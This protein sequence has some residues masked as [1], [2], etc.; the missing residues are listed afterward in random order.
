MERKEN[1][2]VL[3]PNLSH[4]LREKGLDA[5]NN[6]QFHEALACFD[7]LKEYGLQNEHSE[8]AAVVSLLELQ[9]LQ[10]AK[11]RCYALLENAE[12]LFA[13]VL[14]M[15]ITILVQLHDYTAIAETAEMVLHK[16]KV[17]EEQKQK[18]SSL[19]SFAQKMKR[20]EQA[21]LSGEEEEF[22]AIFQ[23]NDV[24]KQLQALQLLKQRGRVRAFSFL[25]SFLRDETKHPYIKTSIL[26]MLMEYDAAEQVE[27]TKFGK[28]VAVV[29]K[30]LSSVRRS[31][32]A[33]EVLEELE[34]RIG[35]ENPTMFQALEEYWYAI[36]ELLFPVQPLPNDARLI[37]AALEKIGA[38]RFFTEV[39]DGQI[40]GCYSISLS[41]LQTVYD[42]LLRIEKEGYLT[43]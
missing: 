2:V 7:Q 15:Y 6:E 38:E 18:L 3:F 36:T 10:E 11:Q 14:E 8:F 28:T 13:D 1:A 21:F 32:F 9:E 29:P 35:N 12:T 33:Q 19:L 17:S 16:D 34:R 24:S 31:P 41:D 43:V 20:E 42:W 26:H 25:Q 5:L 27:V 40:T 30:E 37:A 23:G 4:R 22:A 39:G